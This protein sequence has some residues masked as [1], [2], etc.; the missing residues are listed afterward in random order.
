MNSTYHTKQK[1]LKMV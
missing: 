1:S